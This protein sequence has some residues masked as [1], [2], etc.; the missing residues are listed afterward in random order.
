MV[1]KYKRDEGQALVVAQLSSG[2]NGS[3]YCRN[4]EEVLDISIVPIA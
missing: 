1:N 3:A 2:M 4:Q